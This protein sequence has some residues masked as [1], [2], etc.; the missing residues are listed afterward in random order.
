MPVSSLGSLVKMW[1]RNCS[2]SSGARCRRLS[3]GCVS[4]VSTSCQVEFWSGIL[5]AV[6]AQLSPGGTV[7]VV[8]L[9]RLVSPERCQPSWKLL[10]VDCASLTTRTR[11][12]AKGSSAVPRLRTSCS[13]VLPVV[14]G[15]MVLM[16]TRGPDSGQSMPARFCWRLPRC[17]SVMRIISSRLGVAPPR[18]SAS[19]S[20][21]LAAAR[22][23]SRCVAAQPGLAFFRSARAVLANSSGGLLVD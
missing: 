17:R 8:A 5:G 20:Q 7:R 16:M 6:R 14:S 22:A 9:A 15:A 2:G 3:K 1:M 10:C 19:P 12:G 23:S 11:G 4:P 18:P 21:S 13:P